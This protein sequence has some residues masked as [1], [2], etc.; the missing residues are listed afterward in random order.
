VI[1][2][3]RKSALVR[4]KEKDIITVKFFA[5]SGHKLRNECREVT[6]FNSE[7][8]QH[9]YDLIKKTVETLCYGL[10]APQIGLEIRMVCIDVDSK[11]RP[12]PLLL[13]NPE[14]IEATGKIKFEERCLS[15]P[16]FAVKTKRKSWVRVK[17]NDING[18]EKEHMANG[19]E[20]VCI[21]HEIDHLNGT[22]LPDNGVMYRV[23]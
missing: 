10:A 16:G 4:G 12:V 22:L 17:Y 20:A 21:Q 3:T 7:L 5:P 11:K 15:F 23:Y 13:I 9:A 2:I 6:E 19:I 14:I 1:V 8:R 18:I